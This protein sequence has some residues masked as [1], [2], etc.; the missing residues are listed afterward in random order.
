[1]TK[2]SKVDLINIYLILYNQVG[3]TTNTVEWVYTTR[4]DLT[5]IFNLGLQTIYTGNAWNLISTYQVKFQSNLC[6][7][8]S[9]SQRNSVIVSYRIG[10]KPQH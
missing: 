8:P 2:T 1:M 3:N 7:I 10:N 9:L 4:F 6:A 5:N